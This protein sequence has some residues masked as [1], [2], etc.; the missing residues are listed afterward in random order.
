MWRCA[1][2]VSYW[3]S[4]SSQY[5]LEYPKSIFSH[6]ET[7]WPQPKF[8]ISNWAKTQLQDSNVEFT[9]FPERG[10]LDSTLTRLPSKYLARST[11]HVYQSRAGL[12]WAWAVTLGMSA[13]PVYCSRAL[14]MYGTLICTILLTYTLIIL[15]EISKG[16]YTLGFAYLIDKSKLSLGQTEKFK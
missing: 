4:H 2:W 7:L 1:I 6:E 15:I 8:G 14:L 3:N 11:A 13:D 5:C 16:I 10:P 9:N 12:L